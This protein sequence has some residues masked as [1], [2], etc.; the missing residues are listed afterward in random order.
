MLYYNRTDIIEGIGLAKIYSSKECM[1]CHYW[2]F[3]H[4]FEFQDSVCSGCHDMTIIIIKNVDYLCIIDNISKSEI[5][6]LLENFVLK[7]RGY[8]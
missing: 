5:I 1:L 8:I 3:N 4:R 2:F 6:N 7:N